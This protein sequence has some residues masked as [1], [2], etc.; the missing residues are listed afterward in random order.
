[1]SRVRYVASDGVHCTEFCG[2]PRKP[3]GRPVKYKIVDDDGCYEFLCGIHV[4]FYRELERA[5]GIRILKKGQW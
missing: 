1:M 2:E 5:G 3:C 4:R